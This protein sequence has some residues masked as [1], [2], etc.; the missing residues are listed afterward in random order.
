MTPLGVALGYIERGWNPVPIPYRTKG[1]NGNGWQTRIITAETAERHFDGNAANIGII[2]GPTSAG[3]TDVDLDCPEAIRLAPAVLP[4]T[5]AKFGR[6]SKRASHWLYVTDL[7]T[8]TD[9][10]A[11]QY[12]HP[13]SKDMLIELRMGGAKGAQTVFPGSIHES[14]EPITWDI[15]EEPAC[16]EGEEL[17]R[18]VRALA[19]YAL[20]LRHWPGEGARHEAAR[21]LG[22]FLSRAGKTTDEIAA[23][24]EAIARAAHDE[25][26]R[27]RRDAAKAAAEA[28]DEGKNAYG[29]TAMCE[30]FGNKVADKIASWLDYGESDAQ[31]FATPAVVAA[32]P[33]QNVQNDEVP[34]SE[35]HEPETPLLQSS[36]TFTRD[37]VPPDYL[38]DGL[39]QRRYFYLL[40]ARTGA[41]KTSLALL[42][43]ACVALAKPLGEREVQKGRV[44]FFAG[45]NPD[46][47]RARWIALA[48]Q[49]HFDIEI[50]DVHFI[51]GKFKISQ[52]IK[53]IHREVAAL[54]GVEFLI[55][56]TSAAYF[57]TDNENDAMQMLHHA[58]R[59]RDLVNLPG[60]PCVLA[61]CH[62]VKNATDDN[63]VPR[64]GGSFLNESDGNLTACKDDWTVELY[65]QGKFR[66]PDFAPMYFMLKTVTH[67]RLKDTRG[68]L[69]PTVVASYLSDTA[70]QELAKVAR[71]DEDLV[72]QALDK[73][74]SASVADLAKDLGWFSNKGE[75]QKSR[76]HRILARLK[77]DG[78][79]KPERGQF[80]LTDRGRK[81]LGQPDQNDTKASRRSNRSP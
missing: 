41:G 64:G 54:G 5:L 70:Q 13:V 58:H 10:A 23:V 18:R 53:R 26:P 75:P 24:T 9:T 22:G 46:D 57:E 72:L 4:P 14:G 29:F 31:L 49:M 8:T 59:L 48:Q 34:S 80:V 3:L 51:P 81:A 32:K 7:T 30:M 36:A 35:Q 74:R 33:R 62:P 17:R 19:A 71:C 43:A 55:I 37:Y 65:W 42:F 78:L 67:E 25:E 50:I 11:V 21:I 28:H 47:I 15:E 12:R 76:V 27:D 60:G 20:V 68:R 40:T 44:L 66:G 6:P 69:I 77:K 52:L 2:L 1:P 79:I 61:N 63:L 45:E 39:L 73:N 38:I 56:D 16:I